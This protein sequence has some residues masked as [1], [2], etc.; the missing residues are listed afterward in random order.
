VQY[1]NPNTGAVSK[2]VGVPAARYEGN[3]D[4]RGGF[5]A[6]Q[7]QT[8]MDQ[9]RQFNTDPSRPM[10]VMLHHDGDN[11]G[12]GS[13]SYYNSNFQNMVNW[14][15]GNANYNVSTVQDYLKRFP[16]PQNAVVHVENGSWAGAD[17]GDPEFKKWLG[18]PNASGWSPDRN[19]WA[20]LTAAKNHVYTAEDLVGAASARNV[21]N[22]T[23]TAAERAWH[24]LSQAQASDHW[25]WDG[26]EVWDSNVTRGSNLAVAQANQALT[27][28]ALANEKTP[29]SVFVPQRDSYNPGSLEFSTTPEPSDFDV[30]TYAYDV[31]GLS[32]VTLKYR[33]DLDGENPIAS[34]QNETYAGGTEVGAWN[35]LAMS[36]SSM[37]VPSNILAATV[38]ALKY[39]ARIAGVSDKLVDYY[40]EAVDTKGNVT[41]TDIQHVYVGPGNGFA[42]FQMDG[43]LDTSAKLVSNNPT[44]NLNLHALHRNG[45]LYVATNDAGEGDDVFIFIAKDKNALRAAPW[46]KGGQVAGWDAFLADENDN[47]YSGWFDVANASLASNSTGANG[48]VLEGVLDLRS[49]FGGS[50]P[51][52]VWI[53]VGRYAT[54]DGGALRPN[55]QVPPTTDGNLNIDNAEWVWLQLLFKGDLNIDGAVNNLDIAD[56]VAAL[57]NASP[58]SEQ[59]YC[60]DVNNDG[61][62]NN[63]DIAPF[64]NLLTANGI[65]VPPGWSA[66]VPEPTAATFVL[67]LTALLSRRRRGK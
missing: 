27:A 66:L 30:W 12:G 40:V 16:V 42:G 1:V 46:A 57:T 4:G 36:S 48:G 21:I 8:V 64:V 49:E 33:L 41:R 29:P 32:S 56:F 44:A 7:Y 26:T 35:A 14:A 60:G 25:Y 61:V 47:G 43:A 58:T 22:N 13:E 67:P 5:G 11:Y 63:L 17:N 65:S 37:N 31:S 10:F 62:L 59:V 55:L 50:I 51:P 53:A 15:N 52:G 3:E 28:Q 34:T 39:T 2:M 23:G 9:Y 45:K 6:L 54:A 19:S 18:D 38:R 20:V 24:Y